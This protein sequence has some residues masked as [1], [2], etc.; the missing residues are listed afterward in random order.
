M[1]NMEQEEKGYLMDVQSEEAQ[2]GK[3]APDYP[4][5]ECYHLLVPPSKLHRSPGTLSFR[6]RF[7]SRRGPSCSNRRLFCGDG[8]VSNHCMFNRHP[9]PA[10]GL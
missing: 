7:E 4:G 5:R 1:K 3:G 8:M 2:D 6:L 9:S 10:G